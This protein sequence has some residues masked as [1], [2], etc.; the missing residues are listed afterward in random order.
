MSP[1][2]AASAGEIVKGKFS[3]MHGI[4]NMA[5][6]RKKKGRKSIEE[7]REE[8]QLTHLT[9]FLHFRQPATGVVT[10]L[11]TEEKGVVGPLA[12]S[13]RAGYHGKATGQTTQVAG[14]MIKGAVYRGKTSLCLAFGI[15]CWSRGVETLVGSGG[16]TR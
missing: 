15:V 3:E 12:P 7:Y 8:R 2:V 13:A 1:T 9:D 10:S 16:R 14:S 5:Y 4:Q 6:V 11:A